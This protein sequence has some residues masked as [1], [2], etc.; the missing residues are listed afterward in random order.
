MDNGNKCITWAGNL[1]QK[2][3]TMCVEADGIICLEASACL[4]DTVQG[5]QKFFSAVMEDVLPSL[6][7]GKVKHSE[8]VVGG[9]DVDVKNHDSL[10]IHVGKDH[11]EKEF[12]HSS[13]VDSDS[14]EVTHSGSF[15]E[16]I[17]DSGACRE[18]KVI[19]N[20]NDGHI[21]KEEIQQKTG[22]NSSME[23]GQSSCSTS[24]SSSI[25]SSVS[26][27]LIHSCK[28]QLSDTG[29]TLVNSLAE[30]TKEASDN[31]IDMSQLKDVQSLGK[32]NLEE[33]CVIVDSS[34]LHSLFSEVGRHSFYKSATRAKMRIRKR[35]LAK[36]REDG[37][38]DVGSNEQQGNSF[39]Q[40]F[41]TI[42]SESPEQEFS[43]SDW[44]II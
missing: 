33:S 39:Q 42:E 15:S 13:L 31:V 22:C 36:C 12:L 14:V 28:S 8:P 43:D 41:L 24:S 38:L 19:V 29:F 27:T 20:G 11:S 17:S 1:Y 3:E 23:T 16:Q 4:Q 9:D 7:Q 34:L 21:K 37:N 26:E 25:P 40:S 35:P 6:P 2:F 32:A 5:V 10:D 44:E 18:L 30:P